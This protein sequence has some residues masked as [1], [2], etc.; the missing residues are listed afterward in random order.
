M[1]AFS[2][3][4]QGITVEDVSRN[5]P[6]SRL[7]EEAIR[8]EPSARMADSGALVAYSGVKTGRSPKDK[9][10]VRSPESEAEIWWGSVNVP[11]DPHSFEINRERAKDFL[12]TCPRLYCIDGF[13]GWDP[14]YRVKFRV[15]CD[16]PYH[17]LFMNVMLIRP[18]REELAN[19]G[20]PD[21][22][23]YNAGRFTANQHTPGMSSKTSVDLSFEDGEVVVLGTEYAGEMKKGVFTIMNYLMPRRGVLSMHCSATADRQTG[24]SSL[25][26][27]LSGTGKTTLSADPKRLLIG[28]DEHCWSDR[29]V[30]NIEGGCYAK[31]IDL[32]NENEPDI[33][34]AL[35]FGALLENVVLDENDRHVDFHDAR[36]TENTRGAYPIEFIRNAKIPCVAGHPTDVIFLTCDAFGVLPPVSKLTASQAMYHFISGYTAKVAGTEVGVT[37]PSA[38]FSP[39]FGGP[40][41]VWH[42]ARYAELLAAKMNQHNVNVWL[43]NTGWSG[44]SHGIGSRVK[45]GYTRA[46]LDA[47]HAGALVDAPTTPD[48]V[49]GIGVV[50]DCPGVPREILIPRQTWSDSA[51]YDATARRLST[52]F[53]ENFRQYE[54]VSE[55]DL[56]QAGPVA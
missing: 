2:L 50:M 14:E 40:F 35:H 48:P 1:G 8:Y 6:P 19:F 41:L 34:Q 37:E 15:I 27:G 56:R 21:Y 30:F 47:I 42:P 16:R 23:I 28:D 7:Y 4:E 49:F 43:V 31:T 45:L 18:T 24:R 9:R 13:A 17:A 3:K 39:C 33:F 51:A 5:V 25:L 46:I 53:R 26:F 12:N 52:L 44:G 38:T 36:I 54:S 32:T 55:V 22:V 20:T 10:V 11:L 29:G